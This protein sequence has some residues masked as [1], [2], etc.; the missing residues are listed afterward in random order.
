MQ[1]EKPKVLIFGLGY[2]GRAFL[3]TL[4]AEWDVTGDF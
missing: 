2:F 1:S 4:S 3:K